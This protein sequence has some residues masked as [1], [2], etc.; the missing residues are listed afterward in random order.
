MSFDTHWRRLGVLQ[1]L[2]VVI[3]ENQNRVL[4]L[5]A[6]VDRAYAHYC[7]CRDGSAEEAR[8]YK[9]WKQ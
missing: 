1:A 5:R 8:A 2:A 3:R 7:R 9:E 4:P 6:A